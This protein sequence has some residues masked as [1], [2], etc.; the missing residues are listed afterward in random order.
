MNISVAVAY[1]FDGDGDMDLF[2]G[3]RSVPYH[4]GVTPQSYLYHNDGTGHFTDVTAAMNTEYM[5]CRHGNRS[6]MGR[7]NRRQQKG[8]NHNRRMDGDKNIQL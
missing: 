1:D 8:T 6:S 5:K 4:Y 7:C 2:V 3:S